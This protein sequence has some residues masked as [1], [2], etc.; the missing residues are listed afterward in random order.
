MKHPNQGT[1]CLTLNAVIHVSEVIGQ[2]L[3]LHARDPMGFWRM[4]PHLVL[5]R[6]YLI[7]LKIES[8]ITEFSDYL[9]HKMFMGSLKLN[10]VE[11]LFTLLSLPSFKPHP[12]PPSLLTM[13]LTEFFPLIVPCL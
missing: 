3:L 13:Q 6:Q 4:T 7:H 12:P 10:L 5:K 1:G 9:T 11:H 8:L 2:I